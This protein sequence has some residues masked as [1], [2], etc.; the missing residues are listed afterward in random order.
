MFKLFKFFHFVGLTLFLG[1]IWVY[2]AQGTPMENELIT[3]YVRAT[4]VDLIEH[5]T[6]PGL[7][8]MIITGMGMVLARP[9]LFKT[10]FFKIK[11][12]FAILSFMLAS[13]ILIIAKRAV[14][15]ASHLP[16]ALTFP[17]RIN[18]KNQF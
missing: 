3:E 5:L 14:I 18:A 16:E 8:L 1:S 9:R 6:L 15:E 12:V 17:N 11:M 4:I 2:I 13:L 7:I 10:T